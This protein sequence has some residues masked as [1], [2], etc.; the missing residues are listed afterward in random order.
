MPDAAVTIA[1]QLPG[2]VLVRIDVETIDERNLEGVC[3]GVAAAGSASPQLPVAVDFA[4]VKFIPSMTMAGLIQLS[5]QFRSRNQRLIL[6]NLQP[7]VRGALIVMR[8]DRVIE[9]RRDLS[10]L[11]GVQS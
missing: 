7:D 1:E 10:D 8:L 4:K 6:I 11:T 3:A 2:L 9:I 5:R